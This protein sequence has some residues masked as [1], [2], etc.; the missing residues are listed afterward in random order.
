MFV[1]FNFSRLPLTIAIYIFSHKPITYY[2]YKAGIKP[3]LLAVLKL[4]SLYTIDIKSNVLKV[5]GTFLCKSF[6]FI[7]GT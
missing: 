7:L 3:T 5:P 4:Y 6:H 1:F 2:E